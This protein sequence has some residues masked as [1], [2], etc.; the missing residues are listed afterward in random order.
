M[1]LTPEEEALIKTLREIDRRNPAGIDGY[2]EAA[3]LSMCMTIASGGAAEAGRRY[4]LFLK[5]RR[6]GQ[7]VDL[8]EARREKTAAD[9]PRP[10]P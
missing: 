9:D 5:Q 6:R 1:K 7:L 4:K 10:R 8:R 2:T 3:H